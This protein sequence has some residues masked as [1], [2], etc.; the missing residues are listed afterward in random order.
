MGN[1]YNSYSLQQIYHLLPE[2]GDMLNLQALLGYDAEADE[3]VI[4]AF[5]DDD[6]EKTPLPRWATDWGQTNSFKCKPGTQC[7][8]GAP[9]PLGELGLWVMKKTEPRY[10]PPYT[11]RAG[12]SPFGSRTSVSVDDAPAHYHA[13]TELKCTRRLFKF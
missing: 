4:G 2:A 3:S 8:G 1:T 9:N 10:N 7:L 5:E 6:T 12:V 13:P 11:V